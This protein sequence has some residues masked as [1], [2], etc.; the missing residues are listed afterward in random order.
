[1]YMFANVS[2]DHLQIELNKSNYFYI[3]RRKDCMPSNV[4]YGGFG[5]TGILDTW[6]TLIIFE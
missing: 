6:P 3:L 1:M 2:P 5:H 4:I